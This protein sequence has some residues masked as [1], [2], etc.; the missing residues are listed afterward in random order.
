MANQK[1]PF[2]TA[3]GR[4]LF[5]DLYTPNTKDYDGNDLKFKH[6]QDQGQQR[7]EFVIGLAIPKTAATAQHWAHDPDWG[8]PIWQAGHSGVSNAGQMPDFSWKITDGDSAVLPKARPNKPAP[9]APKDRPGYPGHWVLTLKSSF[10]PSVVDGT[11][12]SF[13][14]L[15]AKDT[16]MPGDWIQ[17]SGN[18]TYNG[19]Q[20]NAGVYLNHDIVCFLG[21]HKDGRITGNRPDP[22]KVGFAT[23]LA[24]GAVAAPVGG[25][26][27]PGAGAPPAAPAAGGSMPPPPGGAAAPAPS[28]MP[29]P[30]GTTTAVQPNASFAPPPG[31]ATPPPPGAGAPP[32][33]PARVMLPAANGTTYEAFK[34]AGWTDEQLI[35]HGKMAP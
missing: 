23:G 33:A 14:P 15:T 22:T 12:G 5:G 19:S 16:V 20:G 17:V 3:I 32:A 4:F 34:A 25:M 6:G 2:R 9:V 7:N 26:P 8:S 18:A 11:D 29:P 35:Q 13:R 31:G 30:P 24:P 1:F 10:A 27:A 28:S 21:L